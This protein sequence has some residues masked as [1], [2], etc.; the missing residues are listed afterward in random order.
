MGV[1]KYSN[2]KSIFDRPLRG[3]FLIMPRIKESQQIVFS[4]PDVDRHNPPLPAR[5]VTP[6]KRDQVR[7]L[8]IHKQH[9]SGMPGRP[10]YSF[11]PE[12]DPGSRPSFFIKYRYLFCKP[13][14]RRL[15]FAVLTRPSDATRAVGLNNHT[16]LASLLDHV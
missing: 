12:N 6:L 9:Q 2:Q 5:V 16:L 4:L 15:H 7:V 1:V 14:P 13:H 10:P 3:G 8:R 11:S